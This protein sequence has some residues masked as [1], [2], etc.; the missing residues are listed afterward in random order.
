MTVADQPTTQTW[1][2]AYELWAEDL[3]VVPPPEAAFEAGWGAARDHAPTPAPAIRAADSE[4]VEQIRA[5]VDAATEGPW[6]ALDLDYEINGEAINPG[7]GWW[8]VWR[9]ASK[10]H[11]GGVMEAETDF[12]IKGDDG[13]TYHVAGAVGETK[14]HDGESPQERIDAEFIAHARD[15]IPWLLAL[16]AEQ[17]ATIEAVRTARAGH[18]RCELHEDDEGWVNCGWKRAVADIDTAL[19]LQ[20]TAGHG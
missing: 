12:T 11:Y 17:A 16:L 20:R 4:R 9:T 1:T 15:D 13:R 2:D 5:R 3:I 7:S 10:P 18:P 6:E 8:W 14:I 19:G